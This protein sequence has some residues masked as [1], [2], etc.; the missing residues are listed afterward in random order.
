MPDDNRARMIKLAEEFFNMK[1]DPAQLPVNEETMKHLLEIH[2]NTLS[3]KTDENG[4]IAWILI[5]PTTKKVMNDFLGQKITEK[6]ILERTPIGGKYHAIY[7][8]SALVLPEYRNKGLAKQLLIDAIESIMKQHPIKFLFL[9]SFSEE[10]RSLAA[11]IAKAFN[12]PLF[13]RAVSP[14]P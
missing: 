14:C 3:E 2:P 8:C 1:N 5:I 13:Q 10:G 7:L 4:P 11:S 12:L 9:W 6:E